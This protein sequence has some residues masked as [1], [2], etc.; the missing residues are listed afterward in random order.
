MAGDLPRAYSLLDA[1]AEEPWI[2]RDLA[3][4][5]TIQLRS[6][7]NLAAAN[8][9]EVLAT[10]PNLLSI[11]SARAIKTS[12]AWAHYFLGCA[13]YLQNELGRALE[14]FSAVIDLAD[15]AHTRAYTHS[16]IGLALT[17]Q[18]LGRPHAAVAA[19]TA[20]REFLAGMHFNHALPLIDAFAAE[21]G[22]RQ[23][24]VEEAVRWAARENRYLAEDATP[25][26]YAPGL[27]IVRIYL[28]AGATDRLD[29]AQAT[30]QRQKDRA[31]RTH[32][33]HLQIQSFALEA[34]L[35]CVQGNPQQAVA[36]LSYALAL[37]EGGQV[38]RVFVDLAPHLAPICTELAAYTGLSGFAAQACTAIE[39][40]LEHQVRAVGGPA[41]ELPA[42]DGAALA[43]EIPQNSL[44]SP[45][46]TSAPGDESDLRQVLTY[47]EMDV[48][49]L[50]N[51]RLTNKEIARA[52]GISAETVR[53]HTVNLFRKLH[54]DNRRQAVVA[55]HSMGYFNGHS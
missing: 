43:Q 8:L 18:A 46:A 21:L 38:M 10:V 1:T 7:V 22:A 45:E 32:N 27:A 47:R 6:Y 26:F 55:A 9:G 48:L 40:E 24:R 15:F 37:A 17:H 12:V 14:N 34:A 28:V 52:L 33:V 3:F 11:A 50:L 54:V 16:A 30:L 25:L 19:V 2:S 5:R 53:Q 29:E 31:L 49:N 42:T 39:I 36:A 23:G 4:M 51:L 13:S 44:V 35:H 20:A 41:A